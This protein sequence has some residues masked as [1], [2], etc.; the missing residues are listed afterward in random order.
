MTDI[1]PL[2]LGAC[3][4]VGAGAGFLGG[5]LGIG[6]GVVIVPA[7]LLLF[8]WQGFPTATAAPVA[9]ATS[10]ATI[11]ATSI[12]AARAQIRRGSVD[13]AIVRAWTPALLVGSLASGPIAD[14]LP[15]TVLPW[16]I[17]L[18]LLAVAAIMLAASSR[19]MSGR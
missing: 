14:R 3:A 7:L 8:E 2:L 13:W 10:L 4:G 18:F 1:D 11:I 19:V 16:F 12:S 5:L 9:V 15:E 17:G 6:G